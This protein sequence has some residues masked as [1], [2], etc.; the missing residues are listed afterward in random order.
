MP[1]ST[2]TESP[3]IGARLCREHSHLHRR[4]GRR[5]RRYD[6]SPLTALVLDRGIAVHTVNPTTDRVHLATWK[7]SSSEV[8]AAPMVQD[9]VYATVL[10][11]LPHRSRVCCRRTCERGSRALSI[12]GGS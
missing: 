2:S 9:G 12:Q 5:P 8:A 7:V 4:P 3:R 1:I 11:R 10:A 6:R